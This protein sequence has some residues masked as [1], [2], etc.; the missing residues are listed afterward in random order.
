MKHGS[1]I[2]FCNEREASTCKYTKG[3]VLVFFPLSSYSFIC[4]IVQN[5]E[6]GDNNMI[7][8]TRCAEYRISSQGSFA[9]PVL[10]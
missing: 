5:I 9:T 8:A 1:C 6:T 10:S 3:V 7:F 2:A 4:G